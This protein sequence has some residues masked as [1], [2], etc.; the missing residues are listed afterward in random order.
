MSRMTFVDIF[1]ED[2]GHEEFMKSLVRRLSRD[3]GISVTVRVRSA[4]GGH[5]RAVGEYRNYQR[6]MKKGLGGDEYPDLLIVVI[7]GNC[8]SANSMR[9]EIL[10]ATEDE[11]ESRVVP[12]CPDPYVE[13]WYLSDPESFGR[14]IGR[15]PVVASEKC[16]HQYYKQVLSQ[17]IREAGQIVTLGG[18]E[19]APELVEAMDFYR[20]GQNSASLRT[21]VSELRAR[22]RSAARVEDGEQLGLGLVPNAGDPAFSRDCSPP[23]GS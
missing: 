16:D 15:T 2:N 3:E 18:I 12:A 14:V 8:T 22:F 21:L 9:R 20:A 5:G 17:T 7:D 23:G 4:R 11:F 19:F 6:L 13:R 1:V 10:D